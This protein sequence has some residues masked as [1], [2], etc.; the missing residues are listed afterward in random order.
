MDAGWHRQLGLRMRS[1]WLPR[2]LHACAGATVETMDLHELGEPGLW[3]RVA[4][5]AAFSAAQLSVPTSVTQTTARPAVATG[6]VAA[7]LSTSASACP[8]AAASTPAIAAGPR[9]SLRR[10]V[11]DR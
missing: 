11:L 2:R 3:G 7:T 6:S 5:P 4:F 9:W 8:D 1:L 10:H